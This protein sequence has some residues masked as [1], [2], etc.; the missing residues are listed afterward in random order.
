MRR[1]ARAG[2][3]EPPQG[4]F[5]DRTLSQEHARVFLNHGST[6]ID[7]D[8]SN[9]F[10]VITPSTSSYPCASVFIRVSN[11]SKA[12]RPGF[13]PG[14]PRSKRGMI[15]VSPSRRDA[16]GPPRNRTPIVW[17]QARSLAV[18]RAA[19]IGKVSRRGEVSREG[20]EPRVHPPQCLRTTGLQPALRSTTQLLGLD[21]K[22]SPRGFEPL[23]SAV[24]GRRALPAAPRGR[25]QWGR[26]I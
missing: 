8:K 12:P 22:A 3:F 9:H 21:C 4:G 10:A 16:S 25:F 15:S 5:G 26:S 20:I 23:A 1:R 24:T 18:R 7:T 14:T 13:E 6:Q 19:R 11:E 17:L 2:G